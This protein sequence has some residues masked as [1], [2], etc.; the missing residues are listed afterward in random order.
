MHVTAPSRLQ[1]LHL[2][3]EQV[4]GACAAHRRN[5]IPLLST[6]SKGGDASKRSSCRHRRSAA[7]ASR[8]AFLAKSDKAQRRDESSA[9]DAVQGRP[10]ESSAEVH[11]GINDSHGRARPQTL[12]TTEAQLAA[13]AVHLGEEGADSQ[14]TQATDALQAAQAIYAELG[15]LGAGGEPVSLLSSIDGVHL[16][17]IPVY[18]TADAA[19]QLPS[20]TGWSRDGSVK[21]ADR[22]HRQAAAQRP[23]VEDAPTLQQ[24]V[25]AAPAQAVVISNAAAASRANDP[26]S[27]AQRRVSQSGYQPGPEADSDSPAE[28]SASRSAGATTEDAAGKLEL[29]AAARTIAQLLR[30][31]SGMDTVGSAVTS[32]LSRGGARW[33]RSCVCHRL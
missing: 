13:E 29:G 18:S 3:L 2:C 5:Q 26:Q 33:G 6:I 14:A 25:A 10:H 17:D 9:R 7:P 28:K 4:D 19:A 21:G 8:D 15:G 24:H 1:H 27:A 32:A 20:S 11:S 16:D 30:P 12:H 22:S 31:D 23:F